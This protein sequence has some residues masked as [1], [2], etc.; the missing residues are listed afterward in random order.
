MKGSG[1]ERAYR[2]NIAPLDLDLWVGYLVIVG[3]VQGAGRYFDSPS[4]TAVNIAGAARRPRAVQSH[5]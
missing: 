2:M 3:R 1:R 4:P 5:F